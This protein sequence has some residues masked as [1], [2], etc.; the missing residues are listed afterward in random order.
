MYRWD[1]KEG[2]REAGGRGFESSR[3][4]AR[5]Y[6]WKIRVTCDDCDAFYSYPIV[7][8]DKIF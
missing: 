6:A 4:R 3:P 2:T 1:G 5:I 8:T 7:A